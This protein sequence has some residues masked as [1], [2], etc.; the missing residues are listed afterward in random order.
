MGLYGLI[1][2]GAPAIGA[3]V[4]GVASSHF[5]LRLPVFFGAFVVIAAAIWTYG[6]RATIVAALP[7]AG[8]AQ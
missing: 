7:T 3:L 8:E 1:F 2:R 6:K 5:G 4:A